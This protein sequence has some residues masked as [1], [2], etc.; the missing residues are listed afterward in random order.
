MPHYLK[1]GAGYVRSRANMGEQRL[2]SR[3]LKNCSVS[4]YE[5]HLVMD[6]RKYDVFPE[7]G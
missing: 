6:I 2:L 4:F 1:I 3:I 5:L 7:V